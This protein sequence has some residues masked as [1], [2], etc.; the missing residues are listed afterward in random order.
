MDQTRQIRFLIP[1][2]FLIASLL[3]GA[4]L[5]NDESGLLKAINTAD[6]AEGFFQLLATGAV[7]TVPLGYLIGTA[8]IS[9]LRL[10]NVIIHKLLG[11]E[12]FHDVVTSQKTLGLIQNT[13]HLDADQTEKYFY[14]A[15]ADFDRNECSKEIYDWMIRQWNA[16]MV[17]FNTAV[18]LALS[19]GVGFLFFNNKQLIWHLMN[20]LLI[21]IFCGNAICTWKK[22]MT[23]RD[24]QD[25]KKVW[26]SSDKFEVTVSKDDGKEVAYSL[27]VKPYKSNDVK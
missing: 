14:Y 26:T 22:V 25:H 17:E 20:L 11:S 6:S 24:F 13:Y 3:W 5:S 15:V 12:C 4:W 1:P 19:Y 16:F 21:V 9:L 23:M 7:V 27:S 2:F 18:A 8:S 10:S